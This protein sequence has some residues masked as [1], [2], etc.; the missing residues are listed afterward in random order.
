MDALQSRLGSST[1]GE[2]ARGD[3]EKL[4]VLSRRF[5]IWPAVR[6]STDDVRCKCNLPVRT[7]VRRKRAPIAVGVAVSVG[8][9]LAEVRCSA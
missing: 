9:R 7:A 8:V 3:S 1:H 6:Q 5:Y 2:A 4:S